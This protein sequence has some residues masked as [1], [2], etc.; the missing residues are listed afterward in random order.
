M[1]GD[2]MSDLNAGLAAGCRASAL[3]LTGYGANEKSKAAQAGFTVAENV[4]E[5]VKY[6]LSIA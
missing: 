3:V 6:F 4:L 2:R 1:V 5:A